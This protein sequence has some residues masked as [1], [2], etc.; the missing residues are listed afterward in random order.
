MSSRQVKK[1]THEKVELERKLHVVT[2]NSQKAL[3]NQRVRMQKEIDAAE[4]ALADLPKLMREN[5]ELD[6]SNTKLIKENEELNEQLG[7]FK[8]AGESDNG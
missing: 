2:N 4:E 7:N 1:L 3:D 5:E 6:R 8:R